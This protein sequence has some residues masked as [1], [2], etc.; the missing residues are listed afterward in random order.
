MFLLLVDK[1]LPSFLP[2]LPG[3]LKHIFLFFTVAFFWFKKG[4]KLYT[5]NSIYY[6][7]ILFTFFYV[8]LLFFISKIPLIN[9][10][11]GY[12]FTFIFT[13]I[14]I[15]S[16]N[17]KI[18]INELFL[19]FKLFLITFLFLSLITIFYSLI[20]GQLINTHYFGFFRE[21]GAF[22]T[23]L[24]ISTILS[25][26]LFLKTNNKL[27][28]YIGIL[29][30]FF[31]ILTIMKKSIIA[32]FFIW[33]IYIFSKGSRKQKIIQFSLFLFLTF[34]LL[35]SF[36]NQLLNNINLNI[37]YINAAGDDHVRIA[38]YNAAY[39]I[40]KDHFPFGI[41]LGSFGSLPSLYN[42]Y[43]KVYYD[44]NIY[45]IEP[46]SPERV[47]SAEGHDLFDTFWPHILGEVG[48]IGILIFLFSWFYPIIIA[49]KYF[50]K[51][52]SN[53]IKALSFYVISIGFV[54]FLEGFAL[55]TPEIA[56]FII[57]HSC[58][59]GLCIYHLNNSSSKYIY[60]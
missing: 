47:N 54:I 24:N 53:T 48:F 6:K 58:F 13:L 27:Y 31:V 49:I 42:G 56:A 57:F 32:N 16:V 34:I 12:F 39:K 51:N 10:S 9:Y 17:T 35:F 26:V 1:L 30:S 19:L 60:V 2:A 46:L 33:F 5:F 8:I 25:L 40:S 18:D 21:L 50:K 3:G 59:T 29:F 23:I 28:L 20:T 52:S 41:G 55:Y 14:F 22:A 38:M 44:Y 37:E 4:S 43:S 7:M 45:L 11:L 15:L 36:K